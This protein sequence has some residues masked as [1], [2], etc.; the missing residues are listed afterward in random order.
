[1]KGR[2]KK[3]FDEIDHEIYEFIINYIETKNYAPSLDEIV[4]A[5][6]IK[7]KST[8]KRRL[9]YLA[10][11]GL[12]NIDPHVPRSISI[13]GAVWERPNKKIF[14]GVKAGKTVK[15]LIDTGFDH[16]NV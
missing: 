2:P 11:A 15:E 12:I 7:S 16:G 10:N 8:L 9:V 3:R 6:T 13:V 1:M 14:D 4:E 5:I